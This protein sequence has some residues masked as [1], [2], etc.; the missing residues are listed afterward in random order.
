MAQLRLLRAQCVQTASGIWQTGNNV[1]GAIST[2][3]GAGVGI[4]GAGSALT[5]AAAAAVGFT[6]AT[7]GV[8]LA[9]FGAAVGMAGAATL[10]S[11]LVDGLVG[12]EDDL[13]IT[14]NRRKVWPRSHCQGVYKG[15]VVNLN[16]LLSDRWSSSDRVQLWDHDYVSGDDPL[17][18]AIKVDPATTPRNVVHTVAEGSNDG[19]SLYL[20]DF[21]LS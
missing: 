3:V 19:G 7:G 6:A 13:Y 12:D 4:Y 16:L 1:A 20:L 9:V 21:L 17:T 8:G 18:G 15:S 11:G 10:F 2:V 14:V 5:G